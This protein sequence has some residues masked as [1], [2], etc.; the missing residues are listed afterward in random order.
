MENVPEK[1]TDN[2][3]AIYIANS[4]DDSQ[5]DEL[6]VWIERLLEIRDSG[7][8][9]SLRAWKALQLTQK[10]NVAKSVLEL[11]FREA[12]RIAWDERSKNARLGVGG[13][14]LGLVTFGWQGAGIAALGTAVGVPLWVIFGAGSTFLGVLY[15]EITG[16]HK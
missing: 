9:K 6:K 4:I 8:S 1:T 2:Q 10:S 3:L 12:K 16:R 11:L 14:A 7:G 5:R 13:A 15:D